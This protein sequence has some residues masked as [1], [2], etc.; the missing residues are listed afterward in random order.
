[1][2]IKGKFVRPRL[3]TII[4]AAVIAAS[5]VTD[6]LCIYDMCNTDLK[7][8]GASEKSKKEEDPETS[9]ASKEREEQDKARTELINAGRVM[10]DPGLLSGTDVPAV[11]NSSDA[12]QLLSQV[13][14]QFGISGV[15]EEYKEAETVDTLDSIY[16]SFRQMRDNIEVIGGEMTVKTD[17]IQTDLMEY[18]KIIR[19]CVKLA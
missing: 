7:A 11:N 18:G 12:L 3:L 9:Q 6:A 14:S 4:L 15:S 8:Y 10:F 5:S 17:D 2:S 1:M 16:Y 19:G 13:G